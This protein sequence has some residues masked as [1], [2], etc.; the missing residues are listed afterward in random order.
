M[1]DL[2]APLARMDHRSHELEAQAE[3]FAELA[4]GFARTLN[5]QETLRTALVRMSGHLQ[6]EAASVFLLEEDRQV[7]VCRDCVGPVDITGLRLDARFGIVG[8][9]TR[10][11]NCLMVRDVRGHPDFAASVDAGTGFETRSILCSPLIVADDCIGAVEFINKCSHDGLFDASDQYLLSVFASA[12][13][14]AIRN[15]R[16]ATALVEQDRI[17]RELDLAR[18]IQERLLPAPSADAPV[19]GL[20]LPAHVVS[21][22]FFDFQLVSPTRCYFSLGDVSGKG[23]NAALLM[24][25]CSGLLRCLARTLPDPAELLRQVNQELCR[26]ATHGMFVTVA[27]GFLDP[28]TGC[29]ELASA[30]HPPALLRDES[31]DWTALEF[32]A[33]P[34]GIVAGAEF[35]LRSFNIGTGQLYLYSDGILEARINGSPLGVAGIERMIDGLAADGRVQRLEAMLR[36][37]EA[38]GAQ[39]HDDV[40]LLVVEG[41]A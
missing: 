3:L 4:D 20:N 6:A 29:I 5:L 21:G 9:A 22:D 1:V 32:D 7:L 13:A 40:T 35:E 19:A 2:E 18:E 33:P 27:A 37:L 8:R 31:G 36:A 38:A 10:E 39:S 41:L 28:T 12:A 30:G 26:T 34:L 16:M 24:S 11:R 17:R 25:Q 14:M 15:A 23:V